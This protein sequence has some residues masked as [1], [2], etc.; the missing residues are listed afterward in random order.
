M[1][2]GGECLECERLKLTWLF[3]LGATDR[4]RETGQTAVTK[5]VAPQKQT[6]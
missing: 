4:W 3:F 5:D 6:L 1:G 2:S